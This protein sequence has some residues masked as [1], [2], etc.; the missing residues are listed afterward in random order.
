MRLFEMALPTESASAKEGAMTR[1][2]IL[3]GCPSARLAFWTTALVD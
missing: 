2:S 1:Q 3:I